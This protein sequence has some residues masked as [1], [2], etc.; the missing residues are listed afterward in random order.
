MRKAVVVSVLVLGAMLL[1]T[2]AAGTTVPGNDTVAAATAGTELGT[3]PG[4]V[5][6][7]AGSP[8]MVARTVAALR[9]ILAVVLVLLALAALWFADA[10]R[11]DVPG[12]MRAL[13]RRQA[14]DRRGPP[15][16]ALA[17]H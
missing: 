13:R 1:G 5:S 4:P 15:A 12:G 9:P 16:P 7:I 10:L 3:V 2:L 11:A 6:Q 17:T 8:A 14:G